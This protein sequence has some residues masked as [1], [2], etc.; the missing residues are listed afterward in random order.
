MHTLSRNWHKWAREGGDGVWRHQQPQWKG[1]FRKQVTLVKTSVLAAWEDG[2]IKPT[3][4]VV[5]VCIWLNV[6]GSMARSVS[7]LLSCDVILFR[8]KF[9]RIRV[10][11]RYNIFSRKQSGLCNK[12]AASQPLFVP[13]WSRSGGE[14]EANTPRGALLTP[15]KGSRSRGGWGWGGA[16]VGAWGEQCYAAGSDLLL[17]VL[18]Q[19]KPICPDVPFRALW[20][21]TFVLFVGWGA[22][23]AAAATQ[24]HKQGKAYPASSPLDSIVLEMV[25]LAYTNMACNC[26]P[27]IQRWHAGC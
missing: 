3:L 2:Q 22:A 9:Q 10:Y 4:A 13:L 23:A 19:I 8:V 20:P 1:V 26:R 25:K 14:T 16:W 24:T 7:A 18:L 27:A 15:L 21:D 12:S 11:P 17:F 5:C 6:V